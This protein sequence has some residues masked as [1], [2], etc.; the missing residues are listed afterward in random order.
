MK[1]IYLSLLFILFISPITEGNC[2]LSKGFESFYLD[3]YQDLQNQNYSSLLEKVKNFESKQKSLSSDEKFYVFV[4]Y[5]GAYTGLSD[6]LNNVKN[7]QSLKILVAS[8]K[9]KTVDKKTIEQFLSQYELTLNQSNKLTEP[10]SINKKNAHSDEELIQDRN[11]N[12]KVATLTVSGQGKSVDDAKNIALRSA[13]E[14]A[15]GTFISSKTEIFN[16]ELIGDEIVS[17]T[18]G[19]I[20]NYKIIS[21]AELPDGR[22]TVSLIATVSISN[23]TSFVENKGIVVEFKGGLF[24]Q[25]IK[26]QKLNEEAELKA[27][28]NLCEISDRFLRKS[29]D[30][31]VNVKDPTKSSTNSDDFY[32]LDITV[33][34]VINSNYN[35]FEDY[36]YKSIQS[37][38]MN[39]L[40]VSEYKKI[41]KNIYLLQIESFKKVETKKRNDASDISTNLES[42]YFRNSNS[43]IA[44]QNLFFKSNQYLYGF[45]LNLIGL[46]LFNPN[47]ENINFDTSDNE[48]H[49]SVSNSNP[50]KINVQGLSFPFFSFFDQYN[51][52]KEDPY[53]HSSWNIFR[54]QLLYAYNKNKIIEES[55]KYTYISYNFFQNFN[56]EIYSYPGTLVRT[57]DFTP[58][59]KFS[60][61]GLM[62][63][64]YTNRIILSLK[65]NDL[66][67]ISNITIEGVN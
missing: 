61:F 39:N 65:L 44:L 56:P 14:L 59:G 41:N 22:Y 51:W 40:E 13:L 33:S 31:S 36:F 58:I 5:Y 46:G 47:L 8:E 66:E 38:A 17:L 18:S 15:F 25:N 52:Y 53:I 4:L 19:N 42:F 57:D 49:L 21:Q 67:K 60:L 28:M 43:A 48:W 50:W 23:F 11:P 6:N 29:L 16:N 9:F 34:A 24:S 7:Q 20:Q 2:Q 64:S 12:E 30:F 55:N 63:V 45:K 35:S 1:N 3:A 37:L 54:E 32:N 26:I 27:I 10:E 62:K